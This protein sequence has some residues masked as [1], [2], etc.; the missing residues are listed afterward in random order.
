MVV[1][2]SFASSLRG[3]MQTTMS[4]L[5]EATKRLNS[6]YRIN[7]AADDA[8]GLAISEKLRSIDRG[9]RQGLRNIDDGI[10][11][12]DTVEGAS[13]EINDMLHRMKELAVES[14]NGTYSAI[15]RRALDLE[16]QQLKEE[17]TDITDNAE[18]NGLPLFDRHLETFGL[19]EGVVE[20]IEPIEIDG[21]NDML[22]AGVTVDGIEKEIS[23]EIP[24]GVYDAEE[25][26]DIM[27]TMLY[28]IDKGLIIGITKDKRFTLQYEGGALDHIS[29][30]A[31]SLF[32]DLDIGS[33]AGYLLGVT[34]FPKD[35]LITIYDEV[36][37]SGKKDPMPFNNEIS[38]RLGNAD[39]TIYSIRIPA[40]RYKHDKIIDEMNKRFDEL[41]RSGG[42]PCAVEAVATKNDDGDDIIGLRA[43]LNVTGLTGSFITIDDPGKTAHSPIYDI[44]RQNTLNNS[45]ATLTGANINPNLHIERDRNDYFTLKLSYYVGDGKT[46]DRSLKINLLKD[47]EYERDYASKAELADEISRQLK[48]ADVP[49]TAEFKDT[50]G[51]NTLYFE[52]TQFGDDCVIKVDK[53][54]VPSGYMLYDFFDV[55]T[56]NKVQ[57]VP[58]LSSYHS[59]LFQGSVQLG[60]SVAIPKGYGR[61]NVSIVADDANRGPK[62]TYNLELEL[63]EGTYTRDA[64]LQELNKQLKTK[65]EEKGLDLSP[66][67]K[68]EIRGNTLGL[69]AYNNDGKRVY[70]IDVSRNSTAYSRLI[71]GQTFMDNADPQGGDEVTFKTG[72]SSNMP[73]GRESVTSTDGF[74]TNGL[75]Y[76]PAANDINPA[77]SDTYLTYKDVTAEYTSGTTKIEGE[78]DDVVGSGTIT[79]TPASV[80]LPGVMKMF[81]TDK[82][83][84]KLV[85]KEPYDLSFTLSDELGRGKSYSVTIPAGLSRNEAIDYLNNDKGIAGAVTAAFDG[86]N[87]VLTSR[88]QGDRVSFSGASGSLLQ[89]TESSPLA[90]NANAIIDYDNNTVTVPAST[91]FVDAGTNFPLAEGTSKRLVFNACGTE[92]DFTFDTNKEYSLYEFTQELN[93]KISDH[94]GGNPGVIVSRS[95]NGLIFRST[96][97]DAAGSILLGSGST[98]PLDKTKRTS[99]D[100][101]YLKDDGKYYY[102]ATLNVESFDSNIPLKLKNGENDII[103]LKVKGKDEKGQTFTEDLKLDLLPDDSGVT[104]KE[105]TS[106][107]QLLTAIKDAIPSGAHVTA[108]YS[109]YPTR[110]L[111]FTTTGGGDGWSISDFH[112]GCG[113]ETYKNKAPTSDGNVSG[114][115]DHDSNTVKFPAYLKNSDFDSLFEN[116]NNK[117]EINSTNNVISIVVNGKTYRHEILPGD[118]SKTE[119]LRELENALN[120]CTAAYVD[121]SGRGLSIITNDGGTN[122]SVTLGSDNTSPLFKRA[123]MSG[124]PSRRTRV[125]IRCMITGKVNITRHKVEYFNN[126][127]FKLTENNTAV[128]VNISVPDGEYSAEGLAKAINDSL[129]ANPNLPPHTLICRA[130]PDNTLSLYA[131][132]ISDSRMISDFKGPLF[133]RVFQNASFANTV[134]HKEKAGTTEGTSA[135]Y[136]LG[137]NPLTPQTTDELEDN[138]DVVITT[139]SNDKLIFDF[140]YQGTKKKI[141]LT[142]PDGR[143][144]RENLAAVIQSEGRKALEELG[145]DGLE[146]GYFHASVGL[147]AVGLDEGNLETTSEDR[148]VLS[149]LLPDDG[150]IDKRDVLIDGVRGN[151]AY[152]IFYEASDFPRPSYI[153]GKADLSNGIYIER[154]K[155]DT[156][157]VTV[158]G[159][160]TDITIPEGYYTCKGIINYLNDRY[161]KEGSLIRAADKDGHIRLYTAEN[162]DFVFSRIKGLGADDLFYGGTGRDDDFKIGIHAGRR[163]DNYIWYEKTRVSTELMRIS[164]TGITTQERA[165]KAIDRLEYANNYLVKWRAL[166]GANKNRSEYTYDRNQNTIENLE[167][168]E[169]LIRDADIAEETSKLAK[170]QVISQVQQYMFNQEKQSRNNTLNLFV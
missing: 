77:K 66:C 94:D 170:Q 135:T 72:S 132:S 91:N 124:A 150:S 64:L 125:D 16:Y 103:T 144:S 161:E 65:S 141:E 97:S 127:S 128:D 167:S 21:S 152:R 101:R 134:T 113:L 32:Y 104:E 27:D 106:A 50:D 35:A 155:N 48:E 118:Y 87:L 95:G 51:K 2:N 169:S 100:S 133:D 74:T 151:S 143:Y 121:T 154:G 148:L 57:P 120:G 46:E 52:S 73:N 11:Y 20:H 26:T 8:A 107:Y 156:F 67:A 42:L 90:N 15:E 9:L 119:L 164:T 80:K 130:N 38:F 115:I 82:E 79:N 102:P 108:D 56:L 157:N 53:V 44:R 29:G 93:K 22:I 59:A 60:S 69:Y 89:T 153:T 17:I 28:D 40:G 76:M 49:F 13:A 63:N 5:S 147:A 4:N 81:D 168:A 47:G 92:Y 99:A 45:E 75:N 37:E 34:K 43:E 7:S 70:S 116:N 84:G 23:L 83:S 109:T 122:Q 62:S 123:Q 41:F 58:T 110:G 139:G 19:K 68:F 131:D 163:T 85:S 25:L 54:D 159:K 114:E 165:E 31:S 14:A 162:G 160:E 137:R 166:S 145:I 129:N 111:K 39:D 136:I 86:N 142:I 12:L 18:F 33:S 140:S 61:L 3:N 138:T 98:I 36:S 88:A 158:D 149:Y 78:K 112:S 24:H 6:G 105:F 96:K 55:G 126:M 1:D 30:S 146:P 71:Q 117:V 10:S